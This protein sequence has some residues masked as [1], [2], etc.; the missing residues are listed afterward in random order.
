MPKLTQ[1]RDPALS[2]FQ[3]AVD[4]VVARRLATAR[5]RPPAARLPLRAPIQDTVW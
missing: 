5:R 3:S 1:F 4:E 2:L